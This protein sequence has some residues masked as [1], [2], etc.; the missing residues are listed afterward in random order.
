MNIFSILETAMLLPSR[1]WSS[2]RKAKTYDV[3]QNLKTYVE[4]VNKDE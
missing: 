4:K 2:K 3:R 1:K